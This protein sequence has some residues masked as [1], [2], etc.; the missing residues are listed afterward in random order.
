MAGQDAGLAGAGA[1]QHQDRTIERFD[2]LALLRIEACEI[3]GCGR[4]PGTRG[5]PTS[6]RLVVG[7]AV[8]GQL[9]RLGHARFGFRLT[10]LANTGFEKGK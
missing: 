1:R 7:N 9:I 3:A 4:R 2:R 10:T 8:M 5:N 6:R